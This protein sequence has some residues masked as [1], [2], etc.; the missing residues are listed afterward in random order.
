MRYQTISKTAHTLAFAMTPHRDFLSYKKLTVQYWFVSKNCS[1]FAA[2]GESSLKRSR[3]LKL[4][5]T[6]YVV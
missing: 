3:Q 2:I 5:T 6:E 1:S 4:K